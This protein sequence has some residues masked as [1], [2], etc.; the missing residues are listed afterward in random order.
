MATWQKRKADDIFVMVG[1][2]FGSHSM[3]PMSLEIP[4]R[5]FL[6]DSKCNSFWREALIY[7]IDTVKR[8]CKS[9]K[10]EQRDASNTKK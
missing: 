4:D 6:I 3:H 1:K 7:M 2:A 9:S 5:Q 8:S 10:E